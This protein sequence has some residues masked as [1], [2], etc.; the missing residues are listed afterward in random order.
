MLQ[1]ALQTVFF[2]MLVMQYYSTQHKRQLMLDAEEM[3][4]LRLCMESN[5]QYYRLAESKFTEI[6]KLR[7]D[8]HAQIQT[9]S[10]L[11]RDPDG[12]RSAGL[13]RAAL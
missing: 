3:K 12:D 1:L 10:V 2:I 7:H 4:R 11:L 6:S 5:E 8:I 9:V 13:Q